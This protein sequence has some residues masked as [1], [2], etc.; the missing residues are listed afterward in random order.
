MD[1]SSFTRTTGV[2][3]VPRRAFIRRAGILAGGLA[4]SGLLA[5][6]GAQ[7]PA[8]PAATPVSS[9]QA[10]PKPA[11]SK[12]AES[13][14][15]ESAK[16][17]AAPTSAPAAAK[18]AEAAKPAAGQPKRGGVLKF[19]L[20]TD[21]PKLDPASSGPTGAIDTVCSI[22][23]SRLVNYKPDASGV[24]PDLAEKWE[25]SPDGKTYTFTLRRRQD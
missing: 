10:A 20:N 19:A 12:P 8:P 11:E 3:R 7:A 16:P 9:G 22:V 1:E 21:P 17:A 6:C 15:A 2:H 13:K 18:P 24:V 4:A 14:P 23:Y 25:I 5:A